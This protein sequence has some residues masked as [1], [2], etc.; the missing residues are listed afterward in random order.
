MSEQVLRD[1]N[2]I[3]CADS[4]KK[5]RDIGNHKILCKGYGGVMLILEG[6]FCDHFIHQKPT[7]GVKDAKCCSHCPFSK[8]Q[9]PDDLMLWCQ[10]QQ[11]TVYETNVCDDFPV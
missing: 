9:N 2:C 10:W 5:R 6:T 4:S 11:T 7:T 8:R 3:N 1:E